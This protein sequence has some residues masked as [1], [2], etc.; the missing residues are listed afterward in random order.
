MSH[1]GPEILHEHELALGIARASRDCQHT[2]SFGSIMR[3]QG[4]GEEAVSHHVLEDILG[5]AA[6][7]GE[8]S[9]EIVGEYLDIFAGEEESLGFTRGSAGGMEAEEMV[10]VDNVQLIGVLRPKV[11][12]GS[13]RQP[14][15]IIQ[16]T[17]G[18]DCD[19]QL[20]KLFLIE[21]GFV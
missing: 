19:S 20:S 21:F 2:Y 11:G 7:H 5:G 14:T 3:H 8:A 4:A 1:G 18:I 13:E 9:G 6:D 10:L 17:D 15:D 12:T 16:R